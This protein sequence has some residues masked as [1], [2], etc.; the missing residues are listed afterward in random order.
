MRKQVKFHAKVGFTL[1]DFYKSRY[2]TIEQIE[3]TLAQTVSK[4][5]GGCATFRTDGWWCED[6]A[7][8]S[9]EFTGQLHK[10][11]TINLE[12]SCELPKENRTYE[13]IQQACKFLLNNNLDIEWVHVSRSEFTGM[14]FNVKEV[15]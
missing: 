15:E 11:I 7:S 1:Q 2:D 14:H 9:D 4:V 8:H 6:G 13:A 5:C 3:R 10:E 12:V